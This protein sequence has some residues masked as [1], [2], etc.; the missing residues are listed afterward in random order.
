S[1]GITIEGNHAYSGYG[2]PIR[3]IDELRTAMSFGYYKIPD[4]SIPEALFMIRKHNRNYNFIIKTVIP[5]IRSCSYFNLAGELHRIKI[6]ALV[7]WGIEDRVIS[8][9]TG[10]SFNSR[11]VNSRLVLIEKASHAPQLE[12]PNKISSEIAQFILSETKISDHKI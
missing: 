4:I 5:S 3:S 2:A 8:V 12:F 10:E 9:K 11:L 1:S 7:I 6:P